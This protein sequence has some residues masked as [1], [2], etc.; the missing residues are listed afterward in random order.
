MRALWSIRETSAIGCE[1]EGYN[2]P[3]DVSLQSNEW[4]ILTDYLRKRVGKLAQVATFGHIGDGNIHINVI[5]DESKK[6]CVEELIEPAIYE[7]LAPRKGSISSEHGI[8]F[9]KANLLHYSKS[10][11]VIEIMKLIKKVFDPKGIL[12]PYKVLGKS[13]YKK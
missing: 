8:G 3:Y 2:L 4:M 6:K 11:E 13:Y 12:N 9:F 5:C 10:R 1:K 7:W